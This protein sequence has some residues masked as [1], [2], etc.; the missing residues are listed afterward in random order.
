V[1]ELRAVL[2]EDRPDG[3]RLPDAQAAEERG[4]HHPQAGLSVV[5]GEP[6]PE[7]EIVDIGFAGN[8]HTV[9][10]GQQRRRSAEDAGTTEAHHGQL[11]TLGRRSALG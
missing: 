8:R 11:A 4:E 2:P 1:I 9:R 3:D 10:K 6:A 5:V 7:V